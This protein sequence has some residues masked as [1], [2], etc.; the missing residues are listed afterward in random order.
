MLSEGRHASALQEQ[1]RSVANIQ[2]FYTLDG[3]RNKPDG[4]GNSAGG[5]IPA[6]IWVSSQV[7]NV[8][9]PG[10]VLAVL[11]CSQSQAE[12]QPCMRSCVTALVAQHPKHAHSANAITL[13]CS[14]SKIAALSQGALADTAVWYLFSSAWM[15][16]TQ[17]A[18]ALQNVLKP[19]HFTTLLN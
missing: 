17:Q 11:D 14:L 1:D 12:L 15:Q 8:T 19:S 9:R 16:D 7:S 5:L 3:F 10:D 2:D 13:A 18:D 4:Y 6:S